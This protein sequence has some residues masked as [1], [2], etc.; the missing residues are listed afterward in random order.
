MRSL[1][2][3]YKIKCPATIE[4][5]PSENKLKRMYAVQQKSSSDQEACGQ[6]QVRELRI[7]DGLERIEHRKSNMS[8]DYDQ[9]QQDYINGWKK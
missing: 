2:R 1:W 6:K 8:V 7:R 4:D 5:T 9:K 3:V